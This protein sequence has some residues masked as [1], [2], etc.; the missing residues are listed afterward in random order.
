MAKTWKSYA[1]KQGRR[2]WKAI[3]KFTGD[4]YGRGASQIVSKGL[5]QLARDVKMLKSVINSEKLR[6]TINNTTNPDS[7][8]QV[9]SNSTGMWI[10]D[11]TPAPAQG[12]TVNGRT[13]RSIKVHSSCLKFQFY[14]QTATY[15]PIKLVV[16]IYKIPGT[17]MTTAATIQAQGFQVNPFNGVIDYNSSRNPEYFRNLQLVRRKYVTLPTDPGSVASQ[18]TLRE[19]VIPLRYKSHHVKFANDGTG[20]ATGQILCIIRADSGNIGGT[21][22]TLNIPVKEV[23]TGAYFN[24]YI[25]HYYYDN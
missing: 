5:P 1:K 9:T 4:R 15:Q 25:D 14:Q 21:A 6:V 2:A 16:E 20:V 19:V 23:N 18:T 8:G 17:P 22:S 10:K 7:V 12:D 3:K 13:G 24:Y 11:I